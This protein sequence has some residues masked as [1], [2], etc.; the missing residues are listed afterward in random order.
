MVKARQLSE[1]CHNAEWHTRPKTS[2]C[3]TKTLAT[4]IPQ[5][6][7]ELHNLAIFIFA[8]TP[9]EKEELMYYFGLPYPQL[10]SVNHLQEEH[11]SSSSSCTHLPTS[12]SNNVGITTT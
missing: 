6:C 12:R 8:T 3:L 4:K 9:S 10:C 2:L 7:T 11:E 5:S 1:L